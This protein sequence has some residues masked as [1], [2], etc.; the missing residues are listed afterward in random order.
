MSKGLF[1]HSSKGQAAAAAV[2]IAIMAGVIIM[3][4]VLISPADRESLLNNGT[5]TS[6]SGSDS[7]TNTRAETLLEEFPGRVDF[8]QLDEVEHSL[9]SIRIY[10]GEESSVLAEKFSAYAKNGVFSDEDAFFTFRLDDLENIENVVLTFGV[11]SISGN[12]QIL[13]NGEEIFNRG[14]S[15]DES[16]V[17]PVPENL[18]RQSNE[19]TF[20]VSSPGAAFWKSNFIE[21]AEIKVVGEVTQLSLQSAENTFLIS[22][23]EY[24]NLDSLELQFQPD[25]A[26]ETVGKL[27]VKVNSLP[28]YSG[29]PDCGLSLIPIE[30]SR[31]IVRIGENSLV[32]FTDRGQYELFHIKVIS[33]LKEINYPTYFFE[34]SH[35][36][37]VDIEDDDFSVDVTLDFIEDRDLKT[38]YISIN[39]HKLHFDTREISFSEDI[40]GEIVEGNNAIVLVPSRTLNVREFRVEMND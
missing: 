8:L 1:T 2:L 6:G 23:T 14:V 37:F 24:N 33:D 13:W 4:V 19:V 29:V 17:V 11:R 36:E 5:L 16:P 10:T 35:E 38:G 28:I 25:C 27:T 7:L 30:F 15:L 12:L 20:T 18:L 9:A 22:E 32:F 31:D 39:N 26:I 34:L 40:S 3:F 21:L